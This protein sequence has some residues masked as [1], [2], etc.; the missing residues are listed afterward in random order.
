M[1]KIKEGKAS[2][3]DLFDLCDSEG[4]S[5]GQIS[6]SEF[7]NLAKRLNFNLSDHR[8]SEIY[9]KIKLMKIAGADPSSE[10]LNQ[11][12]FEKAIDYI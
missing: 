3:K 12:E 2:S 7:K 5:S 1:K 9:S 4:D 11:Q 6:K 8:I 10:E